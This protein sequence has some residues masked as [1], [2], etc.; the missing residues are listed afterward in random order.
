MRSEY[1]FRMVNIDLQAKYDIQ[2]F[3][4]EFYITIIYNEFLYKYIC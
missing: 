4:V 3:S 2:V 1:I